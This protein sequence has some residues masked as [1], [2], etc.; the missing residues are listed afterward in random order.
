[1]E[2]KKTVM[3]KSILMTSDQLV[4]SL[5]LLSAAMDMVSAV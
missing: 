4:L 1:M 2:V 3:M 5:S